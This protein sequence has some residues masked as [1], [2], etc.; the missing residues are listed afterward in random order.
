M[1]VLSSQYWDYH[2]CDNK[3]LTIFVRH[4]PIRWAIQIHN[5]YQLV[6][7]PPPLMGTMAGKIKTAPCLCVYQIL[8]DI[9]ANLHSYSSFECVLSTH[10]TIVDWHNAYESGICRVGRFASL[11][12]T[13]YLCSNS[14]GSDLFRP[15]GYSMYPVPGT[16]A[17]SHMRKQSAARILPADGGRVLTIFRHFYWQWFNVSGCLR[18]L[19][20]PQCW[21]IAPRSFGELP[22]NDNASSEHTSWTEESAWSRVFNNKKS[23]HRT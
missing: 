18:A 21:T 20:L 19:V 8:H 12:N 17:Q 16:S 23:P 22:Q 2:K 10:T 9:A 7:I 4:S 13:V 1:S 11:Q 14:D 15:S 5:I 6:S 3:H